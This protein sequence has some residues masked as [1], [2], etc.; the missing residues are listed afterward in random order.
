MTCSL[1][2]KPKVMIPK[3]KVT[4]LSQCRQFPKLKKT[5][6]KLTAW[7][8]RT[9]P[10]IT[11]CQEVMKRKMRTTKKKTKRKM[12]MTGWLLSMVAPKS[13]CVEIQNKTTSP[14]FVC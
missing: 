1:L 8:C 3:P 13:G 4:I 14:P 5:R 10:P 11:T 6:M 2:W 7:N 9:E 12:K